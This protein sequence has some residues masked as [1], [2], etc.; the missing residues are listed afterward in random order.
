VC[1]VR[2]LSSVGKNKSVLSSIK[3]KIVESCSVA[4]EESCRRMQL[5]QAVFELFGFAI[6]FL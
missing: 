5:S 6:L 2:A 3:I 1:L 4:T